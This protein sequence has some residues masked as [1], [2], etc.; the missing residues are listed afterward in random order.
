MAMKACRSKVLKV[1]PPK[2]RYSFTEASSFR[3]DPMNTQHFKREGFAE[4]G[5]VPVRVFD[6]TSLTPGIKNRPGL[7][8]PAV[9]ANVR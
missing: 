3:S 2:K 7:T 5:I 4:I 1:K 9:S 6:V 8:W